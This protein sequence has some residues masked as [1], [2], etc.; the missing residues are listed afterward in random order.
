MEKEF[1]IA[2]ETGPANEASLRQ[3]VADRKIQGFVAVNQNFDGSIDTV[4]LIATVTVT[5][6]G[7]ITKIVLAKIR[8]TPT[9]TV[10]Y[11]GTII[12]NVTQKTIQKVIKTISEQ[13]KKAECK[14]KRDK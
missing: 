10:I 1:S 11:D 14:D 6:I 9:V 2:Y 3:L 7:A 8:A 5:V 4:T 12:K 13:R